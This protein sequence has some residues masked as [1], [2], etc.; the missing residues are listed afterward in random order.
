[1]L[2]ADGL[3]LAMMIAESGIIDSAVNDLIGRSQVLMIPENRALKAS[4][5]TH[6][7]KWRS[8][9][10]RRITKVCETDRFQQELMLYQE[11][12]QWDEATFFEQIS[13]VIE[14]LDKHSPFY[15]KANKTAF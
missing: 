2:G 14:R 10:K 4:V 5:K 7:S 15:S 11:V 12:I 3:N 6:I 13:E 1:M 9:V 8:N